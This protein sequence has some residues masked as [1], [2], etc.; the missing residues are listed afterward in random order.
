MYVFVIIDETT[1]RPLNDGEGYLSHF[2]QNNDGE[3]G[4]KGSFKC[5]TVRGSG[6][7]G[8]Q[9]HRQEGGQFI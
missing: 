7:S 9:E 1:Y 2:F 8:T 5:G 6:C 3:K 4:G